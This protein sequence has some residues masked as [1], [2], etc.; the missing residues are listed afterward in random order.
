MVVMLI[1]RQCSDE[2]LLNQITI[3]AQIQREASQLCTD[4]SAGV[5]R[6]RGRRSLLLL[7]CLIRCSFKARAKPVGPSFLLNAPSSA[8]AKGERYSNSSA[9][10]KMN[11]DSRQ[12][13]I[14]LR[15]F[16]QYSNSTPAKYH[17]ANP[18][19]SP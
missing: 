2:K 17:A 12:P 7:L 5:L 4:L 16:A 19:K 1:R 11:T 18:L 10:H 14:G 15:T 8:E 13:Y 6:G 3:L 9:A